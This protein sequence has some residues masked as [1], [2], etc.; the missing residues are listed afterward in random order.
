MAVPRS[1]FCLFC[2]DVRMEVGNKPSYMGIY[3]GEM[4]FPPDPPP[5]AQIALSK[6]VILAWLFC[7]V[8]DKPDRITVHVYGPPGRTEIF[9]HDVPAEQFAQPEPL[10]DDVTKLVFH[11]AMPI[12]GLPVACDGVLEVTIE[13]ERET[14]RAG[15]LRLR[16]PGRPA[17]SLAALA[18]VVPAPGNE[19]PSR[20]KQSSAA[21]P[22]TKRPISHGR[23]PSQK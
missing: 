9:K 23:R 3:T 8:N 15:R 1:A 21:V 4:V 17:P 2:D 13:T 10:F 22:R 12:L 16:L 6:F 20:A 7:D 19:T 14:L 5:E 11:I 18:A